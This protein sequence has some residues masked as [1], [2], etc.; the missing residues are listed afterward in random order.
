MSADL[1]VDSSSERGRAAQQPMKLVT[2]REEQRAEMTMNVQAHATRW[3]DLDSY[4]AARD[5]APQRV[6]E[7]RSAG[8]PQTQGTPHHTTTT[9]LTQQDFE[10]ALRVTPNLLSSAPQQP[11]T[12]PETLQRTQSHGADKAAS[13]PYGNIVDSLRNAAL[14]RDAAAAASAASPESDTATQQ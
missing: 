13:N 4:T 3:P 9:A 2:Q 6:D 1:I 8:G 10:V 11:F 7:A 5:S 14:R 12:A